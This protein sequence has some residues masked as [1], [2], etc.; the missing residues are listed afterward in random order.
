[1]LNILMIIITEVIPTI[2]PIE[3]S[4]NIPTDIKKQTDCEAEFYIDIILLLH[5]IY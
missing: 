4:K 1:M 3:M 5:E 2:I